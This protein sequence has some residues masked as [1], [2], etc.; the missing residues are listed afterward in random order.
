MIL[1]N[2]SVKKFV[3]DQDKIG[4]FYLGQLVNSLYE[5]LSRK[6]DTQTVRQD[7]VLRTIFLMNNIKYILKRLNKFERFMLNK[8]NRRL[9][10]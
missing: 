5:N 9:F 4:S 2:I 8:K 3:D 7:T 10:F 1:E 6:T